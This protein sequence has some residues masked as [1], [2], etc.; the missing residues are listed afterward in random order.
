MDEEL[1]PINTDLKIEGEGM[2]N[3]SE[4]EYQHYNV[5][6]KNEIQV[7][8]DY[9]LLNKNLWDYFKNMYPDAIEIKRNAYRDKT[10]NK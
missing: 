1:E 9:I 4:D 8:K 10:G 7:Q 2:L 6:L 3:Y 5:L